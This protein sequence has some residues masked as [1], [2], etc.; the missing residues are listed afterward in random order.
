MQLLPETAVDLCNERQCQAISAELLEQAINK[1]VTSGDTVLRQLLRGEST[2]ADWAWLLGLR[3][4]DSLPI[5]EDEAVYQSLRR[6]W[7]VVE[8]GNGE[9]QL[10]VPLLLRWLRERG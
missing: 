5:P 3:R 6:R 2:E 9:W 8:A 1:A 10:R 4:R 7:L